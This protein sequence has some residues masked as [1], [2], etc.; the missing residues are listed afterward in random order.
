[1]ASIGRANVRKNLFATRP[2]I[3]PFG[4]NECAPGEH[5]C[6]AGLDEGNPGEDILGGDP[7]DIGPP[8]CVD[9]APPLD[10]ADAVATTLILQASGFEIET[11]STAF[12]PDTINLDSMLNGSWGPNGPLHGG[13]NSSGA[14]F[15][16]LQYQQ[17][18]GMRLLQGL[19]PTACGGGGFVYAGRAGTYKGIDGF[20]GYLGE[21]DTKAG[22]SNNF[23][24]EGGGENLSGG[25]AFNTRHFEPLAFVP[26]AKYAGLV[27]GT[28][29][30]GGYVGTPKAGGGLYANISSIL[31]C[32]QQ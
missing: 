7:I 19:T 26:L 12:S 10:L 24:L 16:A 5:D 30:V 6:N 4:L 11:V 1:V 3:D 15:S 18:Q 32:E 22:W 29:G 25:A 13:G 9:I 8:C 31:N 23:L 27:V 14:E 20:A 21:Y 17:Y 2:F 28:T